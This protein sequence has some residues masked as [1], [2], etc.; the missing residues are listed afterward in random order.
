MASESFRLSCSGSAG[1]TTMSAPATTVASTGAAARAALG[2]WQFWIA[3]L[4]LGA[5]VAVALQL[6]SDRESRPYGLQNTDLNGYAALAQVLQHE[7]VT[8]HQARNAAEAQ[9]LMQEHPEAGVVVLSDGFTPP[10]AFSAALRQRAAQEQTAVVWIAENTYLL[11]EML[12]LEGIWSALPIPSAATGTAETL[13]PGLHCQLE[14]A[15]SAGS[16][17]ARGETL[18]A[19]EG[20]FPIWEGEA[21]GEY[22]LVPTDH[23]IAFAAP[24]AFTNRHITAEGNAAIGL[25]L[26]RAAAARTVV[27]ES[28]APQ[29]GDFASAHNSSSQLIWYT[30]GAAELLEVQ[31]WS[32]PWDFLPRWFWPLAGW[33]L[34]GTVVGAVAY[35]RRYGP[36]V[37]EPLPVEVPASEAAE[38]RAR[39]YTHSGTVTAAAAVLRNAALLKL[40]RLLRLGRHPAAQIVAESA[41]RHTGRPE[42]E[43]TALLQQ[44]RPANHR[45]LVS[46]AQALQTLDREVRVQL[47]LCRADEPSDAST[48][49]KEN[50]EQR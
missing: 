17:Q 48:T 35:G 29:D 49:M 38:G 11:E 25:G 12:A 20:C 47:G 8:L 30:P 36:V 6:T 7:G 37:T 50:D 9:R 3:L 13:S 41:A 18:S 42:V 16:L 32:S 28:T 27:S 14:F 39:M 4:V 45:E 19:P 44:Q 43:V 2:R 26:F 5:I 21:G 23:G 22:A 15:R 46:Y 1:G 34:L 40:A 33:L 10:E 31:Q 24:E